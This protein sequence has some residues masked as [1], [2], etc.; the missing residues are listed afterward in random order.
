MHAQNKFA[1]KT[2]ITLGVVMAV[3]FGM[4]FDLTA[5]AQEARHP[6]SPPLSAPASAPATAESTSVG[7]GFFVTDDGHLV[8]SNHVIANFNDVSVLLPNR[9][10]LKAK[11]IKVDTTHD[12]A[13]L[14]IAAITP[15]VYLSH[16]QGVPPGM[17]VVTM[18]YPHV[19]IQGLTPK[20]TRG[21]VNSS[22][23]LRD[24]PS[25]FQFSAEI[26]KGN[27]GGP[28]MGPGGTVVGVVRSKLDAIKLSQSTQDLSQNVNYATKSA[29][30]LEFLGS[31][32][33]LPSTRP[34]D[35]EQ[36]MRATRIYVEAREAVVPVI[37]R[38]IATPNE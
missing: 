15:F 36:P 23:G 10:R 12:L 16:S 11:V 17:D 22:T 18:G 13:L 9:R 32:Q 1:V 27:S 26:Q 20:I 30:L 34:V 33:G 31:L 24:D 5:Y 29:R 3:V 35:P 28:L 25:S 37:A 21:I 8:T 7:T 14:K 4:Q 2:R 6:A 38:N 19:G